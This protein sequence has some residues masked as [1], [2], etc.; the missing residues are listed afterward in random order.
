[1][2]TREKIGALKK[3]TLARIITA[4]GSFRADPRQSDSEDR[5]NAK[6]RFGTH[7]QAPDCFDGQKEDND[8]RSCIEDAAGDHECGEVHATAFDSLIPHSFPWH[9]LPDLDDHSCD[10]EP[11]Y[12]ENEEPGRPIH[13]AAFV[14]D[15]DAAIEEED[16]D[17]NEEDCGAV[18]AVDDVG[19]L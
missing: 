16:A 17:F 13:E 19:P 1:M 11:K 3:T 10:F 7:L 9:T 8:V 12:H 18:E 6:L 2:P 5:N 4:R 15:E 14:D